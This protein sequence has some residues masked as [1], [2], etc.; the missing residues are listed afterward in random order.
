MIA[1][2]SEKPSHGEIDPQTGEPISRVLIFDNSELISL[3]KKGRF[4]TLLRH[5]M[6]TKAL[7]DPLVKKALGID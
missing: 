5:P 4:S 7:N 6:L 1:E 3:A 2:S